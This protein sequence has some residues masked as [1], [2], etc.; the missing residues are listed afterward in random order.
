M[1]INPFFFRALGAAIGAIAFITAIAFAQSVRAQ[2]GVLWQHDDSM[3]TLTIQAGQ[4]DSDSF[5]LMSAFSEVDKEGPSLKR[6]E[7]S[8]QKL[9]IYCIGMQNNSEEG[10]PVEASCNVEVNFFRTLPSSSKSM[11]QILLVQD[12]QDA[13]M[14]SKMF[15]NRANNNEVFQFKTSSSNLCIQCSENPRNPV[16]AVSIAP[17]NGSCRFLDN[18]RSQSNQNTFINI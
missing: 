3:A 9:K 13:K 17:E 11:G 2:H 7:T 14:L 1:F 15:G 18:L 5:K 4:E 8:D 10:S 6:I 16:C 12:P